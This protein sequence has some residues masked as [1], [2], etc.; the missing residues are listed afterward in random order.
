L[1]NVPEQLRAELAAVSGNGISLEEMGAQLG[2]AR[3]RYFAQAAGL[4]AARRQA[5]ETLSRE[6]GLEL[7]QLGMPHGEFRVQ[8]STK[9]EEHADANGIDEIEFQVQLNPGQN[10][11][12]LNRAASGGELSRISLALEVVAREASQISTFVFDEVDAGIG[13]A[14]ADIIGR[15]LREIARNR[16]V[17]CVTHL[18]QVASHGQ[19]HYRIT[20]LTHR[21]ASRTQ[22]RRLSD[23]DRI[24][25]FSRMLGGLEITAATRAHAAELIANAGS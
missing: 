4:S 12:S 1:P 24:E 10:F 3:E 9:S 20:K 18:A 8:F 19:R 21:G 2:I 14:T 11:G 13:G 17:L 16:Q 6:V 15:R 25:E 5:A 7:R 23:A 22:V